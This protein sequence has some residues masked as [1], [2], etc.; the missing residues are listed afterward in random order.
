MASDQQKRWSLAF[1]VPAGW[2]A[3]R[4]G[5]SCT[6]SEAWEPSYQPDQHFR[7]SAARPMVM[8]SATQRSETTSLFD[9]VQRHG[10]SEPPLRRNLPIPWASCTSPRGSNAKGALRH[11]CTAAIAILACAVL[12]ASGRRPP[13]EFSEVGRLVATATGSDQFLRA[14]HCHQPPERMWAAAGYPASA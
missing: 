6:G 1:R 4:S 14:G 10:G 9:T 8:R 11:S 3:S 13:A 7:G 5:M 2:D 12:E